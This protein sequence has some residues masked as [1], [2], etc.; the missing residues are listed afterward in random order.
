MIY[1]F[2]LIF[3]CQ[4]CTKSLIT[5]VANIDSSYVGFFIILRSYVC[6]I[7]DFYQVL[8]FV[9]RIYWFLISTLFGQYWIPTYVRYFSSLKWRNILK[10]F[11][12]NCM[13]RQYIPKQNLLSRRVNIFPV[14]FPKYSSLCVCRI[15]WFLMST[16][17]C[18]TPRG[19]QFFYVGRTWRYF[20]PLISS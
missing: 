14:Q 7:L 19:V 17:F 16:I 13:N 3:G 12:N 20:C 5:Y 8:T 11:F 6:R 2:L 1:W 15:Y 9:C 4:G 10:F 18:H